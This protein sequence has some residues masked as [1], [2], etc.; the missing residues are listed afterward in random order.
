MTAH[1]LTGTA[2]GVGK[3][4][5]FAIHAN[6]LDD[7]NGEVTVGMTSDNVITAHDMSAIRRY[8]VAIMRSSFMATLY[9]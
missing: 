4:K 9:V 6:I 3:E 7:E 2:G 5:K 1:F 8:K